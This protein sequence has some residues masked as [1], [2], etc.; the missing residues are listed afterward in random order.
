MLLCSL[1]GAL[2]FVFHSG[3]AG[4]ASRR[5]PA[6]RDG[7]DQGGARRRGLGLGRG[8][9]SQS[10]L[11]LLLW[12]T[13]RGT[14]VVGLEQLGCSCVGVLFEVLFGVGSSPHVVADVHSNSQTIVLSNETKPAGAEDTVGLGVRL[15]CFLEGAFGSPQLPLLPT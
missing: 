4:G 5:T 12:R 8:R 11:W 13:Y 9:F 2:L 10:R 14:V 7:G 6:W 15:A 3:S 1:W